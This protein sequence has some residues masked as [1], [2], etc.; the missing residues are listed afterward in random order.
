MASQGTDNLSLP[1]RLLTAME[2]IAAAQA[3]S[4]NEVLIEAMDRYI[5]EEQW[6]SL[7]RYGR[8]QAQERGISEDNV[9]NVIRES[10][11]EHGPPPIDAEER[12]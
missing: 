5:K 2:R 11:L 8:G 4:V 6:A 12:R 1:P 9:L 10:R 3:C 7:K